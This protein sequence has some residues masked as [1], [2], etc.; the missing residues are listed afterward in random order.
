MRR[1][2]AIALSSTLMLQA[3]PLMAAT[4]M[5]G[6]RAGVQAPAAT[7]TINGTA[8]SSVGEPLPNFTV[9]VRSLETNKLAGTTT[10]SAVGGYSFTGLSSGNYIV[11]IVDQK[12]AIVGNSGTVAVA[13]GATVD[14]MV[15]TAT[16]RIAGAVAGA[17]SHGISTALFVT[18][19][20]AAAGIA[21]VVVA[22]KNNASPSR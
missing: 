9:R 21:G 7:G 4:A 11:E 22:V 20:A 5:G 14:V 18:T 15:W 1:F 12:G 10:T 3:A 17:G 13:T 19:A 2:V 16:G 6:T 8:K